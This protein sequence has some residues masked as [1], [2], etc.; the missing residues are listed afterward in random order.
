MYDF[1]NQADALKVLNNKQSNP[2]QTA[3]QYQ[4]K[5]LKPRLQVEEMSD[6]ELMELFAKCKFE[7]ET[8]IQLGSKKEDYKGKF[9]FFLVLKSH[10]RKRGLIHDD[11]IDN[12]L[13]IMHRFQRLVAERIGDVNCGKLLEMAQSDF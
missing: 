3:Q 6:K 7:I 1:E 12:H 2:W 11:N 10:C 8:L 13:R 5:P 9:G 4:P